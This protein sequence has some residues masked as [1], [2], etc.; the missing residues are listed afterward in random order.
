[1]PGAKLFE[2]RGVANKKPACAGFLFCLRS[3][4]LSALLLE[5]VQRQERRLLLEQV[6]RQV[7]VLR[8]QVPV[9]QQERV[10]RQEQEQQQ[11]L[12]QVCHR[13]QLKQEPTGQQ[14]ERRVSLLI[15]RE[16][17]KQHK[18]LPNF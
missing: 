8:Q 16:I 1:M 6:Q 11:E 14:Q 17:V 10:Q 15:P 4:M 13:K 9:Q 7:Q 5:Q 3:V 12:R 2:E 18:G